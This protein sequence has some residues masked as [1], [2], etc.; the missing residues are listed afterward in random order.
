MRGRNTAIHICDFSSGC[1]SV[2]SQVGKQG[3]DFEDSDRFGPSFVNM[4]TGDLR[5]VPDKHWFWAFYQPWRDA[6]RPTE[7]RPLSTPHGPLARAVWGSYIRDK[8][9]SPCESRPDRP[10]L[11]SR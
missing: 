5:P 2:R 9:D 11:K 1:F 3:V 6:G 10:A 7:G 4:R 8:A